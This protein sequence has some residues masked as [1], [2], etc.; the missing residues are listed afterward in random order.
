MD[1]VVELLSRSAAG[2]PVAR[3]A[4]FASLYPSLRRLAH[5][6]LRGQRDV[7]QLQTTALVHE[8]Y[9][10]VAGHAARAEG[11]PQFLAYAAQIM[12]S[13]ITDAARARLTDRRGAG[14]AHLPLDT[15][16]QERLHVREGAEEILRVHEAVL[17]LEAVDPRAARIVE[18]R[19][20]AGYEDRE[21]AAALGIA[22]RTV[23]RDWQKAR[24]I[25][26]E[27]LGA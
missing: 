25:L 19:W 26:A 10:R 6:R 15:D 8:T 24:A 18:M 20:F 22:E 3:D 27:A 5:A 9:L 17:A 13:V 16:L 1:D 4:L 14:A 12:R 11:L 2:D 7:S 21:I 23:Q